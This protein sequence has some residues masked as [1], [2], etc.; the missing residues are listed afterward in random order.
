ML[1][2]LKG[3]DNIVNIYNRELDGGDGYDP[4]EEYD[5]EYLLDLLID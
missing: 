3:C 4:Y 1:K 5:D 2:M